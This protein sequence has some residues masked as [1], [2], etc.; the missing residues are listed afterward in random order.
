MVQDRRAFI[1]NTAIGIVGVFMFPLNVI[2][3]VWGMFYNAVSSCTYIV[4][5]QVDSLTESNFEE[6]LKRYR[7]IEV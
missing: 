1:S 6:R 2:N 7:P 3:Y 4:E 5:I